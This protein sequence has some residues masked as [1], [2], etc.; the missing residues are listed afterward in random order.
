MSS[1]PAKLEAPPAIFRKFSRNAVAAIREVRIFNPETHGEFCLSVFGFMPGRTQH[2]LCAGSYGWINSHATSLARS[3]RATLSCSRLK[4]L[5][6]SQSL[7]HHGFAR[8]CRGNIERDELSSMWLNRLKRFWKD[9]AVPAPCE[10]PANI[11]SLT[12]A[13]FGS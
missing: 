7:S 10:D 9:P 2:T 11:C 5:N 1:G 12:T 3:A 13:S 8:S 4:Q 6:D